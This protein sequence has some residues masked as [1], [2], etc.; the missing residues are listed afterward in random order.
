MCEFCLKHGEGEKWYL[1]AK[2]Y[3]EDLMSDVRR[4]TF[5]ENF[6]SSEDRLRRM[7]AKMD[8]L[9]RIPG[10]VRRAVSWNV[11]RNAKKNH[12]GQVVPIEDVERILAFTNSVVRVACICRHATK[13]VDARCCYGVSMAPGGGAMGRLLENADKS[14][15][16]GP[17]GLMT[18]HLS[19]GEALELMRGHEHEGMCH[20]VWTFITP[21]IG[22]ICNCDRT[23]CLAMRATVG[24]DLRVMFRG[25]YV[26]ETNP[27]LCTGCRSCM[28]ICQ[29]GAMGFSAARKKVE[30]DP[31]KCFGCGSCRSVCAKSAISLKD[32]RDVASAKSLW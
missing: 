8:G 1:R 11:T 27:D 30:I 31:K 19:K 13:G 29:F 22:G 10:F 23:D 24:H 28:R 2:N 25:E 26:A 4:R 7:P 5:V 12:F 3:S 16:K 18:E 14:Y 17:D 15:L 20:T 21:F 6:A 32:R 9:D